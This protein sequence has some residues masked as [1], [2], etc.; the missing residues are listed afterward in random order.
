MVDNI[1]GKHVPVVI[2]DLSKIAT[3]TPADLQSIG[4]TYDE[5]TDKWN[6]SDA[7]ADYVFTGKAELGFALPGTLK[8]ITWPDHWQNAKDKTTYFPIYEAKGYIE[9]EIKSD[10]INFVMLD[11]FS[12]E[13][14]LN[15]F[16]YLDELANDPSVVLC[17]SSKNPHTMAAVG[18]CLLN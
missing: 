13:T 11:C 8:V 12:D 2:A 5:V 6:I 17:L 7:A 3:I 9:A 16:T 4:Y 1:G 18:E 15:D 14:P 10:T